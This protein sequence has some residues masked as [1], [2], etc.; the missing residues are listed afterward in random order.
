MFLGYVDTVLLEL[1]HACSEA[2]LS[3]S[4]GKLK[5]LI[6]MIILM[7]VSAMYFFGALPGVAIFNT[8]QSA[9]Q[10]IFGPPTAKRTLSEYAGIAIIELDSLRCQT[11]VRT[12]LSCVADVIS[13][14][15]AH[16]VTGVF[17]DVALPLDAKKEGAWAEPGDKTL[18]RSIESARH[19]KVVLP[20]EMTPFA[21]S[22]EGLPDKLLSDFHATQRAIWATPEF[23]GVGQSTDRF[24]EGV[25]TSEGDIVPHM[26]FLGA[27]LL[28]GS[29][30]TAQP[31]LSYDLV[32]GRL[33]PVDVSRP[34]GSLSRDAQAKLLRVPGNALE[35]PEVASSL[36]EH[37]WIVTLDGQ[38]FYD[39]HQTSSGDILSGT[40]LL[41]HAMLSATERSALTLKDWH[42]RSIVV[43]WS[44]IIFIVLQVVGYRD[45]RMGLDVLVYLLGL[46]V[47]SLG[48]YVAATAVGLESWLVRDFV[49][50]SM[51][52]A[53]FALIISSVLSRLLLWGGAKTGWLALGLTLL[54]TLSLQ[55][56]AQAETL[57]ITQIDP[58]DGIVE[59]GKPGA[60]AFLARPNDE[61]APDECLFMESE[62]LTVSLLGENGKETKVGRGIGSEID[63]KTGCVGRPAKVN[64]LAQTLSRVVWARRL[65]SR[66]GRRM[67]DDACQALPD[68]PVLSVP[69]FANSK[70]QSLPVGTYDLP[71]AFRAPVSIDVFN[72]AIQSAD[73]ALIADMRSS[74]PQTLFQN[75]KLEPGDYWLKIEAADLQYAF[76]FD[77]RPLPTAPADL[78]AHEVA[79]HAWLAGIDDG[80]YRWAALSEIF[81]KVS[82]SQDMIDLGRAL[83]FGVLFGASDT[84]LAT[85]IVADSPTA[86]N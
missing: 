77:V 68:Y 41:A 43:L 61:V 32:P 84:V 60:Y 34:I 48:A 42:I 76:P 38:S 54:A 86:D 23:V 45:F 15:D 19:T 27:A 47:L 67:N 13:K 4:K 16:Q 50:E 49:I 40:V 78:P 7:L 73:G 82:K 6:A 29:A 56:P 75:V 55:R 63:E 66:P 79:Q 81:N 24:Y 17:V 12:D 28:T 2:A 58:F 52:L 62:A 30:D 3:V 31:V 39:S 18:L 22:P 72:I 10:I 53:L 80:R 83:Q 20:Q 33:L 9:S 51:A 11:P 14:A 65:S 37:I 74:K 5:R 71:L 69:L 85:C 21:R 59:I 70:A 25:Q 35:A 8:F 57:R 64:L 1:G 36:S 46:P 44:S 26:A